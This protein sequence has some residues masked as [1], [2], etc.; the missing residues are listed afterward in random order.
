MPTR[1][2]GHVFIKYVS[3]RNNALQRRLCIYRRMVL[4]CV[5]VITFK[6]DVDC[7][8]VFVLVALVVSAL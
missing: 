8:R 2:K 4:V 3:L 1:Y 7:V 6:H 5:V